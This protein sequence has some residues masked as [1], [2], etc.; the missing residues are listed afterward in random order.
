MSPRQKDPLE[1]YAAKRDFEAT[2]EPSGERVRST[3]GTRFVIQQHSAT[4]LHWDLRLERDGVLVSWALPRGVPRDPKENHLA[5]HTEDHPLE[6]LDFH[7][8]IPDGSYGAG[9]MKV[10][11][12]G[13]YETEEWLDRKAVVVF[14]GRRVT[15]KYALFATRGKDWMIHRMD[16]PEDPEHRLPP[17]DLQ[18]MTATPGALPRGK[19]W[20][21]EVE[22]SGTR[23]LTVNE[24]GLTI[25]SDGLAREVSS[26]F[27]D[28]RRIGRALG[29][30]EVVLDGVITAVD[31]GSIARRLAAKS[32]STVRRL[33]RDHPATYVI[34]DVLWYDGRALDEEPWHTRRDLLDGLGLA[35][36]AWSAP[37]AHVGD[38]AAMSE[39]ARGQGVKALIAKRT[40]SRYRSGSQ[41]KDW[42]RVVL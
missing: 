21:F 30:T 24:P 27:P 7:G 9:S 3:K 41:S 15:G 17:R 37:A 42:I 5:V 19:D 1:E 20:A 35:D 40:T 6:Y 12:T 8:E 10:W 39:A 29:A 31:E 32:D 38:G 28:V 34:F 16:P 18:A 2:P 26:A 13:T 4:R 11:D 25:I 36:D 23:A 22:W 33:A 14:H